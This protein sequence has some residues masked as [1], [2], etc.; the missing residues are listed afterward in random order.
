MVFGFFMSVNGNL[1]MFVVVAKV[2]H[3]QSMRSSS[4]YLD[5]HR[6]RWNHSLGTLFRLQSRTRWNLPQCNECSVLHWSHNMDPRKARL[7]S[8]EMHVG[9]T[10]VCEQSTI[11]QSKGYR[12]F[13]CP[14]AKNNMGASV[15]SVIFQT[16]L[17]QPSQSLI[18]TICYPSFYEVN[19][20]AVRHGQKHK[21]S[22][23]G[24]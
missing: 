7:C 20:K 23:K 14:K 13:V 21:N 5:H 19:T 3:S 18:R 4:E 9:F 1:D 6:E 8:S 17:A 11:C 15:S 12:L 10:N 24:I 16:N 2:E 22:H